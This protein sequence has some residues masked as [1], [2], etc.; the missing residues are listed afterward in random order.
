MRAGAD[1]GERNGVT[2]A[3]LIA[4]LIA[5]PGSPAWCCRTDGTVPGATNT[6]GASRIT[7][8]AAE[9]KALA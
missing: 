5:A 7:L 4:A 6:G 2:G 9:R 1:L 3:V 8:P